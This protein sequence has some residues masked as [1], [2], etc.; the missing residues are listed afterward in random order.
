MDQV[1]LNISKVQAINVGLLGYVTFLKSGVLL[2]FPRT[3][4]DLPIVG[5]AEYTVASNIESK[6]RTFTHTLSAFLSQTF[7]VG[8]V[9]WGF[10][11]TDINGQRYLLGSTNPPYPQS[12]TEDRLPGKESS[13]SGCQLTVTYQ[14]AY[15]LLRVID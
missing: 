2:N 5:L 11:L 15:G 6:S 4:A 9:Y 12:K 14:S 13:Q 10:L 3:W 8:D 1:N 7:D